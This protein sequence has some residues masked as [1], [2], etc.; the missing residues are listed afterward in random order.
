MIVASYAFSTHNLK[1]CKCIE[2]EAAFRYK[3]VYVFRSKICMYK[4]VF[5]YDNMLGY[6]I[7]QSKKWGEVLAALGT[8]CSNNKLYVLSSSSLRASFLV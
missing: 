5:R 8:F 6:G 1:L 2:T 4:Q 3:L 7:V